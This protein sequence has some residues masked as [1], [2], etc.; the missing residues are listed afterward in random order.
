MA[1]PARC[2]SLALVGWAI[3]GRDDAIE[4]KTAQVTALD[5]AGGSASVLDATGYV[6]ARRMATVSAKIT[7]KVREVLIEE[8]Q[9]VEAGQVMATLDPID[10][11]AQRDLAASQVAA[12]RSQIGS[13]QAQLV[14]AEANAR[15]LDGL[16]QQQLVSKAQYDQAI[17]Q[18]DAL[19]A[20]LATA[21][22]NAQ[23]ASGGL[24]IAAQGVDNT[25]VRAPFSRRGHR[26][27]R[28]AG[29]DRLAA[30]RRRRLHPHRHRHHRRHGFARSRS[31]R[32]RGLHRPRAAED[33]GRSRAQRLSRTGASPPR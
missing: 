16:V 2:S 11:D 31:R 14:E 3:F 8:G 20:Q 6:V 29:R 21:Q 10:A 18:R 12:A 15:R 7:G 33:A 13:V 1:L 9:R 19:R 22:R 23:V 30:V 5:S 27:G 26:Q 32:Q 28:A 17:A 25:I 4:V 24:R